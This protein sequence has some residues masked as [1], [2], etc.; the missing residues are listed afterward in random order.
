MQNCL[1]TEFRFRPSYIINISRGGSVFLTNVD[2]ENMEPGKYG[3]HQQ[4]RSQEWTYARGV[5][6]AFAYE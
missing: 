6:T 2:F 3:H 4:D 5:I 1:L